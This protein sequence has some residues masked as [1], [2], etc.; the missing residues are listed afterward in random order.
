[1]RL[2]VLLHTR[3][4]MARGLD[5]R[6]VRQGPGEH[7]RYAEGEGREAVDT[8]EDEGVSRVQDTYRE[9]LGMRPYDVSSSRWLRASILLALPRELRAHPL[10]G[11]PP[12]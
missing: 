3:H 2:Q 5:V 8:K 6:R 12:A 4:A 7:R 10:L 1:M 11:Q 9:R